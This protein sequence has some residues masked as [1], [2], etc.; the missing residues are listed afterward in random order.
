[1]EIKKVYQES[2]PAVQLV[3]KRFVKQSMTEGDAFAS[4]WQQ[5]FREG[6]FD[7]LEAC[8]GIPGVSGDYLGAMRLIGDTGPFEY[9]IGMFLAPDTQPPEGFE[10]AE[11]PAGKLG[12]CWLYGKDKSGELYGQEAADLAMGAFAAKGWRFDEHGWFFERYNCP[13]FTQPDESGNVIL[14]ICA[15]LI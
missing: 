12:V 13:R 11:I 7:I 10:A 3:G 6:W 14:D 15:C 8:K 1:M 2:L 4:G 9:W 5:A